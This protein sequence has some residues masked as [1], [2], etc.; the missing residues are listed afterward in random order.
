MEIKTFK[1]YDDGAEFLD[2]V[3]SN[4]NNPLKENLKSG[5]TKEQFYNYTYHEMTSIGKFNNG[6]E[7]HLWEVGSANNYL[8]SAKKTMYGWY[9]EWEKHQ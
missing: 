7:Y 1:I 3:F 2:D 6:K 5:M 9:K 4:I 8:I